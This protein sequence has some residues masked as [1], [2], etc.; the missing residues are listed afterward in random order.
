MN[1]FKSKL[2][3][4]PIAAVLIAFCALGGLMLHRLSEM[5][6]LEKGGSI[7]VYENAPEFK[8]TERS[9]AAV[10][11]EDLK[12]RVWVANYIF[13]RCMGPC[14]FMSMRAKEL[15][16]GSPGLTVVSFSSDPEY[17]SPEVLSR[18]AERYQADPERWLF[19]TGPKEEI[20]RTASGFKFAAIDKPDLHS[21]RFFLVDREARVR[22]Y[23]SSNDP[24]D[25]ARLKRD[26]RSLL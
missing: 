23:Y 16:A 1:F 18:Y 9:G 10:S 13:T 24:D 2:R 25:L 17:D 14:P 15:L 3:F 26:V 8:L 11:L 4:V 21:T 19:L 5:G 12:G 20:G 7:P 22:G 6:Y